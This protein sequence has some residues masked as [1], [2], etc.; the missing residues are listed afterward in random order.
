MKNVYVVC[1]ADNVSINISVSKAFDS[2]KA[3]QKH[4]TE[5]YHDVLYSVSKSDIEDCSHTANAYTVHTVD[6]DFY[7]GNV[8][9]VDMRDIV[10]RF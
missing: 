2:K 1:E 10:D 8:L 5:R 6:N 3:A 7:Y 9:E 4:L